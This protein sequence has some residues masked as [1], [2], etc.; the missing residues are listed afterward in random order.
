[1]VTVFSKGRQ[2]VG[3]FSYTY[4]GTLGIDYKAT[5]IYPHPILIIKLLT[6]VIFINLSAKELRLKTVI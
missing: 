4:D 6:L 5:L 1:M 2:K 3:K